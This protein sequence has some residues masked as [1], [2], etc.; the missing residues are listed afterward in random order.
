MLNWQSQG[1]CGKQESTHLQMRIEWGSDLSIS[2]HYIVCVT[3]LLVAGGVGVLIIIVSRGDTR[4]QDKTWTGI[5]SKHVSE[6]VFANSWGSPCN[7][8]QFFIYLFF[9][10]IEFWLL[11]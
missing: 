7:E 10:C 3:Q 6:G 9:F 11:V 2:A 8:C 5:N 4:G 1:T